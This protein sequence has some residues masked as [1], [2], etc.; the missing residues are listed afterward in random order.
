MDTPPNHA[1]FSMM[2]SVKV[3]RRN[4]TD[5]F[6]HHSQMATYSQYPQQIYY[7][8]PQSMSSSSLYNYSDHDS[9]RSS[10]ILQTSEQSLLTKKTVPSM[11]D[12]LKQLDQEFGENKFTCY[13]SVFEEQEILV[14][15]L[16]R[17]SD[18]EYISMDITIIGRRQILRDEAK[19]YFEESI[20]L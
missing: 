10:L 5:D 3:T 8:P 16:T 6:I 7:P 2:H 12:F 17:L 15:Q 11:E 4:S 13:L 20:Y 1:I 9:R 19:K 18:S 14:S